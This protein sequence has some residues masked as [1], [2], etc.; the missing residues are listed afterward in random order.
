MVKLLDWFEKRKHKKIEEHLE[1]HVANSLAACS[2]LLKRLKKDGSFR[3]VL[4]LEEENDELRRMIASEVMNSTISPEDKENFIELIKNMDRITNRVLDACRDVNLVRPTGKMGDRIT[5]MTEHGMGCIRT[6][7]DC[8]RSFIEGDKEKALK[9]ADNIERM[10]EYMDEKYAETRRL[11]LSEKG[12][13]AEILTL[14]DLAS[15]IEEIADMAEDSAD[16]IRV[17]VAKLW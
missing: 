15:K 4:T 8:L 11:L 16:V 5:H 13:V 2:E 7:D 12:S 17:M 6:L 10:E 14:W 9:L 3:K 1:R